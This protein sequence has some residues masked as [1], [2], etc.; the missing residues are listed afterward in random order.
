[1]NPGQVNGNIIGQNFNPPLDDPPQPFAIVG[2]NL[3]S[4]F[5]DPGIHSLNK[6]KHNTPAAGFDEAFQLIEMFE[7]SGCDGVGKPGNTVF[8]QRAI[9]YLNIATIFLTVAQ[10]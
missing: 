6:I 5:E 8:D 7:P 1:L 3:I 4:R 10:P 2:I 9:F